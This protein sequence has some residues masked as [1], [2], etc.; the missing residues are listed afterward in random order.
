MTTTLAPPHLDQLEQLFELNRTFLGFVQIR[1]R[2]DLDCL[3]LH[4]QVRAALRMADAELLDAA[5]AFP[6]ALFRLEL[7]APPHGMHAVTQADGALH[8]VCSAIL[9]SARYTS[10][11][12]P[13]QARLLFG[14]DTAEIHC[15]RALS[16]TEV[17]R[18]A[19]VPGVLRCAF[20]DRPWLWQWLLTAAQSESRSQ[21]T[22]MAL[23]PGIERDWPER[24]APHPVA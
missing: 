15:L 20:F 8:D 23:Q 11:Q 6:N 14:L 9:W 18:L 1:A 12:S 17:Q 24:R 5:A 4:K 13:Y 10:R 19:W 22:L 3:G 16:V 7:D 21:L 2:A